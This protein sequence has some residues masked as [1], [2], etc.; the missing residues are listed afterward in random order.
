MN[1]KFLNYDNNLP[2]N[3]L[4]FDKQDN[5]LEWHKDIEIVLLLRGNAFLD[6]KNNTYYLDGENIVL[7]NSS[8]IH[9]IYNISEDSL[10]IS[11]YFDPHY[12]EKYYNN[13][14]KLY[15]DCNSSINIDLDDRD[16]F[17]KLFSLCSSIILSMLY[18]NSLDQIKVLKNTFNLVEHLI[19]SFSAEGILESSDVSIYHQRFNRILQYINDN[20]TTKITL[21]DL[22]KREYLTTHYVSRFFNKYMGV[23]FLKYLNNFR[24]EKS[25]YD[26][27]NTNK[28]ILDLSLDHGFSS[29]K[30]YRT[31]FFEKYNMSPST[32]RK[33]YA[34][35]LNNVENNPTLP[36]TS[37]SDLID[38]LQKYESHNFSN[39]MVEYITKDIDGISFSKKQWL[40]FEKIFYFNNVYDALNSNWQRNFALTI[41][42]IKPDFIKFNGVFNENMYDYDEL[43]NHYNWYNIES[44]L[45]FFMQNHVNPFMKIEYDAKKESIKKFFYRL[46]SFI[47]FCIDKYDLESVRE[48]KFE[49]SSIEKDYPNMIKFYTTILDQIAENKILSKLNFGIDFTISS[50]FYKEYFIK[51]IQ[52]KK[53]NFISVYAAER[54]FLE[55][56][57]FLRILLM[58]TK[59]LMKIKTYF[60]QQVENH[61]LNDTSYKATKIVDNFLNDYCECDTQVNFIDNSSNL[62][63]FKGDTGILT[64][65]GLK[66]PSFNA[67]FTLS[68]LSGYVVDT[69]SGYIIT[70]NKNTYKILLYNHQNIEDY[71]NNTNDDYTQLYKDIKLKIKFIDLKIELEPG[72]YSMKSYTLNKKNGS[73]Y[74]EWIRMG[75]PPVSNREVLRFLKS[76]ESIGLQ[77]SDSLIED[78]IH[79][80]EHIILGS[81]KLIEISKI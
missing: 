57:D 40:N 34:S 52:D 25:M 9:R 64:Y 26:L 73:I 55:T 8:E 4:F 76:K 15:F 19:D 65:N 14:E 63:L 32:Y 45:D 67:I 71:F 1:Y 18:N 46:E 16:K 77:F 43:K 62:N 51:Y 10:I 68:K 47:L 49:L 31:T 54:D 39:P 23:G 78:S 29:L 27:I 58:K 2:I 61:Y 50:T 60:I 5:E 12:F 37:T 41:D 80:K 22:A 74:D 81:L 42:L 75:K 56:K 48:W 66:K 72:S 36:N 53:I 44:V 6:I 13:F 28:S 38:C 11:L 69:G 17:K 7:I 21:A 35:A 33:N 3:F 79:L 24:L 70:K 59:K 20:Y 30:S